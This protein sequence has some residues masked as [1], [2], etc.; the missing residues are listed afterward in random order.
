MVLF[1][2]IKKGLNVKQVLEDCINWYYLNYK[3]IDRSASQVLEDCI[4]W[5]Y[6]NSRASTSTSHRVLEDCINWYYLNYGMLDKQFPLG[7]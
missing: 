5:Y 2:L 6:L 1:E 7:S 4:N 3:G